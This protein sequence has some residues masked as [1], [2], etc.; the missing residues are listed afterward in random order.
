[1]KIRSAVST[2][3][4]GPQRQLK[5]GGGL[6]AWIAKSEPMASDFWKLLKKRSMCRA[7]LDQPV[8]K[9]QLSRILEAA[10]T[11]PSAGHAQGVR[12]AVTTDPEKRELIARAFGEQ[13]YL[14]KGYQPW[15]SVAPVHIVAAVCENDYRERYA[16]PDKTIGPE[17]WQVPYPV[18]D[19]GK[20]L[21][22]LYLAAEACGLSCGYLGPHAGPDLITLLELPQDWRF[23]GLVTLGYRSGPP[24][25]TR[26]TRRGWK[27][28]EEIV[29]WF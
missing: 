13:N 3:T 2:L 12:F 25:K 11:T 10:R 28:I 18:M 7:Y 1:M 21:M 27:P 9:E 6:W 22:T 29:Y 16:E 20:S 17:Q 4:T 15:L 23:L 26:S 24:V 5:W 19:G 14:D 8:P